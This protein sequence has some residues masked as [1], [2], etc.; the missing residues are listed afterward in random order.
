MAQI[1][2]DTLYGIN[3]QLYAKINPDQEKIDE[4]LNQIK[5][6]GSW[7]Q[8][9][10]LLCREKNDY[11]IFHINENLAFKDEQ[12]RKEIKEVLESRGTIIDIV[13]MNQLD[14]CECWIRENDTNEIFMY[15]FFPCQ[16][17]VIEVE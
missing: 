5:L 10:M 7:N 4:R 15:A 11:T 17:W 8:Y 2:L 12:I 9:Y 16:D 6:L 1:E 13:Q 14:F 3:K